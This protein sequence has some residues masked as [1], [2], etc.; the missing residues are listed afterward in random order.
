MDADARARVLW[1]DDNPRVVSSVTQALQRHF[2]ITTAA[3]GEAAL[4]FLESQGP[5]AVLVAD[6]CLPGIFNTTLFVRAREVAPDTVRVM[7]TGQADMHT[8]R[9]AIN[10]GEV[11]RLLLKPCTPEALFL[12]LQA[13]ADR[14]RRRMAEYA[15]LEQT[16]HGSLQALAELQAYT[17]PALY[18]RAS[19]VREHLHCLTVRRSRQERWE[20]EIAAMLSQLGY[21]TLSPALL[22]KLQEGHSLTE[23]E[24]ALVDSVPL[25]AA[26]RL[27]PIPG[28]EA[29][30]R[31]L[32]YQAKCYDGRGVPRDNVRGK[33][34]PWG[35]RALRIAL[36][37]DDLVGSGLSSVAAIDTLQGRERRGWYDAE[38]LATFAEISF[39]PEQNDA[40]QEIPL[41]KL[42]PGMVVVSD[43]RTRTGALLIPAGQ[44]VTAQHAA[45]L[46][47]LDA[48]DEALV[49]V[50]VPRAHFA[51][52]APRANAPS[53]AIA[54]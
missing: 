14:Y 3:S 1:V 36:D 16:L 29:V 54:S 21:T 28:T 6:L 37:Y 20:T 22:T 25:A 15:R 12:A 31:I 50:L 19:R 38:I 32:A 52:P 35:A 39:S 49:C 30:R 27:A 33:G 2:V 8:A 26:Q 4:Q 10:E 40:V 7:L 46:S 24:Q 41:S 51:A 45:R 5:F 43:V 23:E 48:A 17:H 44:Q 11:F 47:A 42:E 53:A 18:A 9:A 13:A 34:I